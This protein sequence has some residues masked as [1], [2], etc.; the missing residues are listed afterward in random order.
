[1]AGICQRSKVCRNWRSW[2][3]GINGGALKTVELVSFRKRRL[4]VP[5]K[6]A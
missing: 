1:M 4:P 6:L 3:Y 5:P 2:R